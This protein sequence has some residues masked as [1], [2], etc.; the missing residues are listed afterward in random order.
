MFPILIRSRNRPEYLNITLK[1]LSA[2]NLLD[3]YIIIVD[4]CSD[5][6]LAIKYLY[7][8]DKIVLPKINWE[9]QV[10]SNIHK[11]QDDLNIFKKYFYD[12]PKINNEVKGIKNK[13]TI[14]SPEEQLGVKNCLLWTILQGFT[15]YPTAKYIIVLEDDLLFNKDWL[16]ISDQI[17]NETIN[18]KKLGIVT[19]YNRTSDNIKTNP[20]YFKIDNISGQMYLIPKLVFDLLCKENIFNQRFTPEN[21]LSSDVYLYKFVLNHKLNIFNSSSSYIQHIGVKSICREGRY[22]RYSKNF[23]RPYAWNENFNI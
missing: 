19:V 6:Q 17:Y 14:I 1:S 21:N 23:L 18:S 4:D 10:L 11:K 8:N 9:N 7:T 22:L 3:G 16:K 5:N 13:F 2:T 12:L 20:L 15:L